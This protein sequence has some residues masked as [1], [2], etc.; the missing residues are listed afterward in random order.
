MSPLKKS[1]IIEI[2]MTGVEVGG[3]LC[4]EG[5]HKV[6]V[7]EVT[8]EIS[9][10]SEKPYLAWKFRTVD[11]SYLLYHNTSLQPQALFNLKQ[12]L[13]ALGVEVPNSVMKLNLDKLFG[14]ECYAEV[15]HE[16]YEG[17]KKARIVDFWAKGVV[18]EDEE[19]EESEEAED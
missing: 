10:R 6:R 5:I 4:P 17:K 1:R 2:D 3:R 13:I 12:V 18:K 16:I 19:D 8:P 14:K 15:E 7:E 11:G 9:A